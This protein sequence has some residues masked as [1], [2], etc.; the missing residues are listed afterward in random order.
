M[1]QLVESQTAG[2][3]QEV[4]SK[5]GEGQNQRGKQERN[6]KAELRVAQPCY[7]DGHRVQFLSLATG[8]GTLNQGRQESHGV[9][10]DAVFP[11]LKMQVRT[12]GV[13][14]VSYG[15][16]VIAAIHRLALL[17]QGLI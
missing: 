10:F 1:A 13:S 9:Y 15:T 17:R 14:A 5:A 6:V 7:L 2:E 11:D 3:D 4:E 16:E 8:L 12:G